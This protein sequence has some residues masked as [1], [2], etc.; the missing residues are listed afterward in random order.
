M[1]KYINKLNDKKIKFA[2]SNFTQHKDEKNNL[3]IDWAIDNKY[4]INYLNYNYY[5][6]N[7]LNITDEVLITNYDI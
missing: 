1:L 6:K 3:L 7:K 2:I 5:S 4:N